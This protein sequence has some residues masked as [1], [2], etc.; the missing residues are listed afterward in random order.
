MRKEHAL[1]NAE[2]T[3][4]AFCEANHL[5]VSFSGRAFGLVNDVLEQL[6]R[7]RRILLTV[8]QFFTAGRVV[9]NS[10]LITVLPHHLIASTGMT[11]ELIAKELP[12]ALPEVHVDML[13]HERNARSLAHKWLRDQ[14]VAMTDDSVARSKLQ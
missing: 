9:A 1:A 7:K 14:L 4:D 3:L 6:N 12:F 8:N 2:L 11:A 5:L 10:D 13:W